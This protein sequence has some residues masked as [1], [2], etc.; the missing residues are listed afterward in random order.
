[1]GTIFKVWKY[2]FTATNNLFELDDLICLTL[3]TSVLSPRAYSYQW[4]D[5]LQLSTLKYS[6]SVIALG[7]ETY[8][9]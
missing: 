6:A 9:Y 8:T 7:P 5:R 1:M 3:Y 2:Y 4:I